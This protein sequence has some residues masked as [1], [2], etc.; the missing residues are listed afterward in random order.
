MAVGSRKTVWSSSWLLGVVDNWADAG[1][2]LYLVGAYG[3]L[4]PP[5]PLAIQEL[6]RASRRVPTS[7]WMLHISRRA[8]DRRNKMTYSRL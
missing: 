1:P 6:L 7:H 5:Q 8:T 2:F 3:Q 4:A